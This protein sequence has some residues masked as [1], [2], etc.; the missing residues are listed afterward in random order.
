MLVLNHTILVPHAPFS[1]CAPFP[2]AEILHRNL[3][4]QNLLCLDNLIM[5]LDGQHQTKT[6][7]KTFLH[8]KSYL[9]RKSLVRETTLNQSLSS[10]I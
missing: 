6:Q 8:P 9:L 7:V 2:F 1:L 10:K 5:S 4:G 3:P